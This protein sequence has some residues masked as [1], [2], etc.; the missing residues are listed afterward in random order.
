ML[1][2]VR[3][4]A[5]THWCE[6]EVC[7]VCARLGL[8]CARSAVLTVHLACANVEWASSAVRARTGVVRHIVRSFCRKQ[9]LLQTKIRVSQ[10][11]CMRYCVSFL[12]NKE[13]VQCKRAKAKIA[14]SIFVGVIA[15]FFFLPSSLNHFELIF[16]SR[17]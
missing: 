14:V 5:Q 10:H 1:V 15:V 7:T 11:F 8:R 9:R 3:R 13:N 12:I 17:K 16:F 6:R 4:T 2:V